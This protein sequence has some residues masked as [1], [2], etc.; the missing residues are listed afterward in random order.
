VGRRSAAGPG[1][2]TVGFFIAHAVASGWVD[3]M[4][5]IAKGHASSLY[6]LA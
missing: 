3:R 6:P 5:R 1:A 4:A 2:L